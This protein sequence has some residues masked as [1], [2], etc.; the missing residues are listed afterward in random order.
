MTPVAVNDSATTPFAHPVD[1]AVLGNDDEGDVSA[2]LDSGSV[3]LKDP[4]D[5]TWKTSGRPSTVR[6]PSRCRPTARSGSPRPPG[7]PARPTRVSY[8]VADDNGTHASPP[9]R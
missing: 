7:S 4:A 9:S 1:V 5:G 2:P 3:Q 6:A 8:R